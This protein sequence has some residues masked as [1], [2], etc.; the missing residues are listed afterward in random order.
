VIEVVAARLLNTTFPASSGT[1]GFLA[2]SGWKQRVI[3]AA[4]KPTRNGTVSS[5]AVKD[6]AGWFVAPAGRKDGP[7]SSE[8]WWFGRSA[9]A[10]MAAAR[11]LHQLPHS[12][13]SS[14]RPLFPSGGDGRK[15]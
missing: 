6:Q 1:F 14:P 15:G 5:E 13:G 8:R 9:G 10:H 4:D 3:G 11:G 7:G 12:T 2:E